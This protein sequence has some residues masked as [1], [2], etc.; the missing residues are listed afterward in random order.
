MDV[1]TWTLVKNDQTDGNKYC[2]VTIQQI[3]E[4]A[5]VGLIKNIHNDSTNK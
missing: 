3:N 2:C 4:Q 1:L 5:A